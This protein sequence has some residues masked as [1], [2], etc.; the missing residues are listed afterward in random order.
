MEMT[1]HNDVLGTV[2]LS[3][4]FHLTTPETARFQNVAFCEGSTFE[5]LSFSFCSRFL[6]LA[7]RKR[8]QETERVDWSS[9][10]LDT[11]LGMAGRR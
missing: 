11:N 4:H 2:F 3:F 9:D 7:I 6:V 8:V 10:W 5:T 1:V